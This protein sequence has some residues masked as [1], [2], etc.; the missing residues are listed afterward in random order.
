MWLLSVLIKHV[1]VLL[2]D[3][4]ISEIGLWPIMLKFSRINGKDQGDDENIFWEL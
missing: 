2:I 1:D 3:V 4:Y